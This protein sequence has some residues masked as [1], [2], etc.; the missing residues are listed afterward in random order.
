MKTIPILVTLS[1]KVRV[2]DVDMITVSGAKISNFK[3]LSNSVSANV[4]TSKNMLRSFG[5]GK[6]VFYTFTLEPI[7]DYVVIRLHIGMRFWVNHKARACNMTLTA[8]IQCISNIPPKALPF[9]VLPRILK[10]RWRRP[11]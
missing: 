11:C 10:I 4:P 8:S 5:N 7:R 1:E 9:N 2:F 6:G 3:A